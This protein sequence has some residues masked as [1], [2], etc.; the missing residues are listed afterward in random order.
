MG[1]TYSITSSAAFSR[2]NGIVRPS[3]YCFLNGLF[4][5]VP[6]K[7]D[8]VGSLIVVHDL[9]G[10]VVQNGNGQVSAVAVG[11]FFSFAPACGTAPTKKTPVATPMVNALINFDF[12]F[13]PVNSVHAVVVKLE[14]D[15]CSA[16]AHVCFGP[17]ADIVI[18]SLH[19]HAK[20]KPPESIVR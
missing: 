15:M 6:Q 1:Q 2:P 16:A 11:F 12:I 4:S 18:Q 17:K 13:P 5:W 9:P 19:R 8:K 10:L 7:Y 20:E 3:N 14:A